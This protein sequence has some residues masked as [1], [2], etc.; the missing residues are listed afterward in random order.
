MKPDEYRRLSQALKR[1]LSYSSM[2]ALSAETGLPLAPP[3]RASL[4]VTS[5]CNSDCV[6]CS[7]RRSLLRDRHDLPLVSIVEAIDSMAELG[8][9]LLFISG[10]EPL[11]RNDLIQICSHAKG[12]RMTVQLSTN[13]LLLTRQ[14]VLD[15][16]EAGLSNLIMSLDSLED[17][18]YMQHRGVHNPRILEK[19][20]LLAVFANLRKE[21][22][23]A[24]TFVVSQKNFLELP[25]FVRF[26]DNFA[27]GRICVNIQPFH[28]FGL[29]HNQDLRFSSE[30]ESMLNETIRQVIALKEMGCHVNASEDYLH[31]IPDF[32]LHGHLR[33]E[34]SCHVGYFGMYVQENLD[35]LP[36]WKMPPVGNLA[37]S[38]ATDIWL[39]AA[40]VEAR[41]RMIQ[42][43]CSRCMLLCHQTIPDWFE[44]LY[45]S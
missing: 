18:V 16:N 15:L 4:H 44:A 25:A 40:Y 8:V 38:S 6:Y 21:N 10:G 43:K 1:Y 35:V 23:S 26:I 13:G 45:R 3:I 39:S 24:V 34:I 37:N 27:N 32:L 12:R 28:D 22:S 7:Y 17:E 42:K 19:L 36:C 20:D 9:R 11:L 30:Y 31:A 41:N 29:S 33:G 14:I 2:V 5:H